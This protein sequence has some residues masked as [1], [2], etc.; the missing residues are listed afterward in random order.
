M[1]GIADTLFIEGPSLDLIKVSLGYAAMV[2][3]NVHH[4][5]LREQNH[6]SEKRNSYCVLGISIHIQLAFTGGMVFLHRF[7]FKLV[8]SEESIFSLHG[9]YL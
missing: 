8:V 9:L 6:S 3:M 5:P 1:D 7:A 4:P 2:E